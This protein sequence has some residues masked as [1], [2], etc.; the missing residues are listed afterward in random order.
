MIRVTIGDKEY[1]L[2]KLGMATVA[3][4]GVL[5]GAIGYGR[6]IVGFLPSVAW[7][8]QAGH[9]A[10]VA[11]LE[12]LVFDETGLLYRQLSTSIDSFR[13]EWRCMEY[14]GE[15]D[16]LLGNGQPTAIEAARITQIQDIMGSGNL[17]CAQFEI[18]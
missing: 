4:A 14:Q 7:K 10:D 17:R 16:S 8:T 5:V 6:D 9:E 15:L 3:L 2:A 1:S 12:T 18:D 11:R 13:D